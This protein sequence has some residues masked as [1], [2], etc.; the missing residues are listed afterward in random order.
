MLPLTTGPAWTAST[1]LNPQREI[2]KRSPTRPVPPGSGV[3]RAGPEGASAPSAGGT[4]SP[5]G[6]PKVKIKRRRIHSRREEPIDSVEGLQSE[7]DRS[8]YAKH[9][10][11][12]G[13]PARMAWYWRRRSRPTR[14]QLLAVAALA[15]GFVLLVALIGGV[16][17]LLL[18]R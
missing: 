4:M 3:A 15:V 8:G 12:L 13:D 7:A 9:I 2:R 5:K 11:P 1:D 17:T 6:S 10:P 16:I 18:H 14:V